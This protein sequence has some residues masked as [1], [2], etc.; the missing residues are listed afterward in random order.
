MKDLKAR[1]DRTSVLSKRKTKGSIDDEK[2]KNNSN[3]IMQEEDQKKQLDDQ[4]IDLLVVL[5]ASSCD[6]FLFHELPGGPPLVSELRFSST[7]TP[8]STSTCTPPYFSS[9]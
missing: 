3:E 1:Y 5:Q 9:G 2:M 7:A 6:R 8:S 4:R